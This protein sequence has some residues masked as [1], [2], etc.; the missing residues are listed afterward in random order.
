MHIF[1]ATAL[2]DD[3]KRGPLPQ[4]EQLKYLL[5]GAGLVTGSSVLSALS[6]GASD[7]S[8]WIAVMVSIAFVMLGIVW[9]FRANAAG[10]N[11]DFVVRFIPL[12]VVIGLRFLLVLVVCVPVL[13]V[14]LFMAGRGEMKKLANSA[15]AGFSF[16]AGALFALL[17]YW[18]VAVRI[19]MI[20]RAA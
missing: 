9:C 12:H 1:N 19:R 13:A 18:R 16:A 17:F 4:T 15:G 10:D 8:D 6:Q 20:A 2:V 5:V 11:K 14:V 3:L 7:R